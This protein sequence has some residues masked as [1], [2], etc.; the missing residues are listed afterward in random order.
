MPRIE[1]CRPVLPRGRFGAWKLPRESSSLVSTALG[2]LSF[3]IMAETPAI[4]APFRKPLR[5]TSGPILGFS[6]I[7]VPRL[8]LRPCVAG[9]VCFANHVLDLRLRR[10]ERIVM[11]QPGFRVIE[12]E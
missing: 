2:I 4:A 12:F 5:L 7:S 6:S 10:V 3:G 8:N 11:N 9:D 1:H